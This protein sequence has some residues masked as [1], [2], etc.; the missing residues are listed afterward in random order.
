MRLFWSFLVV[1]GFLGWVGSIF[2]IIFHGMDAQGKFRK[3]RTL[4]WLGCLV[5]GY[6]LWIVGLLKAP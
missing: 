6:I 4:L 2:A 5:I 1:G 3:K